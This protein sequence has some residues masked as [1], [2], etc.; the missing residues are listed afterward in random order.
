M[1]YIRTRKVARVIALQEVDSTNDAAA[2]FVA[3]GRLEGEEPWN[4]EGTTVV[5]AARQ[6]AGRGRLDHTWYSAPGQSFVCSFVSAVGA[7]LAHDPK[8]NGWLPMI[9]GLATVDA[10]RATLTDL[11][12]DWVRGS[13]VFLH[14][15]HNLLLKWP[16]DIVYHGRKLGGILTQMVELPDD[17][18]RVAMVF[19]VGLNIAVPVGQ[20]PIERSTSWQLITRPQQP[21]AP[22]PDVATVVD[23]VASRIVTG[24]QQRLWQLGLTPE[25]YT[26][27]L[28]SR[29]SQEC[30]TLGH[31]VLVHYADGTTATGMARSITEDASLTMVDDAGRLRIVHTGDVGILPA[32]D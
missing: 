16:N 10:L 17:P 3:G 30:W 29:V 15:R 4:P 32:G 19:G 6:T 25:A 9:A 12:L 1:P 11:Q 26:R 18:S 5:T 2:R 22:V 24:L 14:P 28:R 7:D 21:G 23:E 8:I 13:G 31:D 27:D 20:L